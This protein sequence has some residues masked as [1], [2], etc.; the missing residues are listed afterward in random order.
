MALTLSERKNPLTGVFLAGWG[1]VGAMWGFFPV[2]KF[3]FVV[4]NIEEEG[5]ANTLF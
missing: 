5:S 1:G 2:D 4:Y 3:V